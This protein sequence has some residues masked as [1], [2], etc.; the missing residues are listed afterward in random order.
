[1][2]GNGSDIVTGPARIPSFQNDIDDDWPAFMMN[3][4]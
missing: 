2:D 3:K 4:E 1:M